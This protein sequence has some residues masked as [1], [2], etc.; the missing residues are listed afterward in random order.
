MSNQPFV[1]RMPV[2]FADVDHA[3]IVY[4]PVFFHYFHMT[5][6][7]FFRERIGARSYVQLLD[8]QHVGFPSVASECRYFAPLRFGDTVDIEMVAVRLGNKSVTFRYRVFR[9][10]D[11][12]RSDTAL[13][14]EGTTTS[15]VVDLQAFRAISM[16]D[17]LREM[18][19]DI[20]DPGE[21]DSGV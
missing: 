8:E 10:A 5:F 21:T 17:D 3:G 13:C 7:E 9:V 12:A 19:G 18:F 20:A 15:A 2:R 11:T 14:A 16:P 1:Y 4:Y 6:E